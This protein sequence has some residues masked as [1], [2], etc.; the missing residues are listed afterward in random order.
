[1]PNKLKIFSLQ[2]HKRNIKFQEN[3]AINKLETI[4]SE[5][6]LRHELISTVS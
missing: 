2:I 4:T 5:N 3:Y 1:M 6:F